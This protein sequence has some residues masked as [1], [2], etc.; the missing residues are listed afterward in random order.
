VATKRLAVLTCRRFV[1]VSLLLVLSIVGALHFRQQLVHF[2][3]LVYPRADLYR[4][5][6]ISEFDFWTRTARREYAL[7]CRYSRREYEVALSVPQE[8][9]GTL[10]LDSTGWPDMGGRFQLVLETN[11]TLMSVMTFDGRADSVNAA[12][13]S[14]DG[15]PSLLRLASFFVASCSSSIVRMSVIE[16]AFGHSSLRPQARIVIRVSPE[17]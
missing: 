15:A 1:G 8:S 9:V 2:I 7:N 16:P 6:V 4:P 11:G 12:S 3:D 10:S 5:A 13:K 17:V 14:T